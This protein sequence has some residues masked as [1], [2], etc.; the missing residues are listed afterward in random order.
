MLTFRPELPA[1][2]S[3]GADKANEGSG[4]VTALQLGYL[5]ALGAQGPTRPS[6]LAESLG[7]TPAAT[8]VALQ[9]L[10]RTGLVARTSQRSGERGVHVE[11]TERGREERELAIL[12]RENKTR[13]ALSKLSVQDCEALRQAVPILRDIFSSTGIQPPTATH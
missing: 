3:T 7:V 9:R 12:K 6:E 8:T 2:F 10:A 5:S 1:H 11:I 13:A 4:A